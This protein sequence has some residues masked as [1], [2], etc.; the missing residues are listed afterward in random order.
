MPEPRRY[1]L[2]GAPGTG[3]T[4]MIEALHRG[5]HATDREAAT[6][7]ISERQAQGYAEPWHQPDRC[8]HGWP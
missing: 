8:G 7:L 1:V 4:T 5:G 3:R 6:D 2:T